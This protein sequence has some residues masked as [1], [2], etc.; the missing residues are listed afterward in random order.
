M[1]KTDERTLTRGNTCGTCIVYLCD[2][3]FAFVSK[4]ITNILRGYCG[5]PRTE[6]G[7]EKLQNNCGNVIVRGPEEERRPRKE[8]D[9]SKYSKGFQVGA[10][11]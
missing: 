1:Q 9:E 2:Y 5:C 11:V 7:S 10:K 3:N 4:T 6:D 8:G